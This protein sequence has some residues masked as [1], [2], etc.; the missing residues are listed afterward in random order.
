[1]NHYWTKSEEECKAKFER[2]RSDQTGTRRWPDDFLHREQA[3]NEVVDTGILRWIEPLR[4]AL[5]V[6]GPAVAELEAEARDRWTGVPV[7]VTV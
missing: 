2:G 1:M 4:M 3:L 6:D 5:G 7:P